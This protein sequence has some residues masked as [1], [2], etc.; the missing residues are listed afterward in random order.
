[1]RRLL[2]L[3]SIV[4]FFDVAFYTAIAPLLPDYAAEFGLGKAGVGVL[5]AAYAAGTLLASL[6]AGLLA[7]RIG[8]RRT[9]IGG[10]LLLGGSSVVFGFA[11]QIV[12]LD[13][14]RFAQGV[15]GALIWSGALTWLL[16]TAPAEHRGSVIGT[17]LGT[18]VAGA[19]V[20][21]VLGAV[22]AEVG[23][24]A[25]FGGVLG[26]AVL[27]AAFASRLP[28]ARAPEE[29]E[30]SEVAAA[31]LSRPVLTA[32]AFVA[33]PSLMFGAVEVLVP[34]RIDELGGGHAL[35]AAGFIAGAGL[36]A[37]LAP[38]AGRYSDR[39][40][41]R[42]PFVAGMSI[43]AAA[44]AAIGVGQALDVVLAGLIVASLGAGICFTPALT[45]LSEAAEA[46]RLHQGFA[47]GLSN[48]AWSAGQVAGGLAGGAVASVA[49][50]AIPSFAV[51]V[52]LLVTASYAYRALAPP[53][54][55]AAS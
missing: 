26:V 33:V 19:L 31:I 41:R 37:T 35:I 2:V 10:L 6:P 51:V 17:V 34:L 46:S 4:V 25:V 7:T 52:L 29:Q 45:M 49:G 18:A 15:S 24:E 22:A 40:G 44:M 9:V 16:T 3:A 12:L 48:M 39:V 36:E 32:T 28:E 53:T 27:L 1:M 14:S 20:G 55:R 54:V 8:P 5:S 50:Y 13:V 42:T 21:P 30:L 47:A 43:C 11:G 23:T 38:I